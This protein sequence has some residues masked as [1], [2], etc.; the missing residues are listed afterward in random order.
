MTT[1]ATRR[2]MAHGGRLV[3][4]AWLVM[5]C[6]AHGQTA[7]PAGAE[8][9]AVVKAIDAAREATLKAFNSGDSAGLAAMFLEDGEVVDENG[10][11]TETRA[12]IEALFRRFFEKFPKVTLEMEVT[13]ARAVGDEV[14]I[15]E[16]IRR[17]T[18]D[19]AAA[20]AQVRYVAVRTKQGD[21]WPIASYRE[22]A[23]DPL[24]TAA[25]MLAP[26]DWLVGEWVDE[27][28]EGNTKISYQ[29][30]ED[31][32]FL[33]GEYNLS[34][35]GQAAAKSVQRIGW[36]PVE[37]ELRSWTFDS[38]GGFS[39]G[40]WM[41]TDDGW[42]VKSEATL[43]DGGTG[44]ATITIRQNDA[45]HFVVESTDRMVAGAEEP[46]FKLVIARKPP[47]PASK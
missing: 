11:V 27:S 28:P 2:M 25:E 43:P 6:L 33:L 26:L 36:D 4:A 38:D 15:E 40:S 24:P 46:D 22:F 20:A 30:S 42:L 29:W 10:T 12:E 32:N 13:D 45:D 47:T 5:G 14:V 8:V 16:G 35:A 37:G 18:A 41:A 34:V 39:E 31:G 21:A 9:P 23:D 17:I 1:D 7:A 3:V 44:S 19:Q